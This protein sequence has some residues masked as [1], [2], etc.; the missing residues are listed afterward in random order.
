MVEEF[1]LSILEIYEQKVTEKQVTLLQYIAS[2]LRLINLVIKFPRFS[3]FKDR[4]LVLG[5]KNGV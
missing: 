3:A 5:N 1:L 4:L 2:T